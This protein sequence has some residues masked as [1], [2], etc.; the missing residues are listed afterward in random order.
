[1]FDEF[2]DKLINILTSR[3]TVFAIFGGAVFEINTA[4]SMPIGTPIITAPNVP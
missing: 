1:M 2:K 3:L 4:H